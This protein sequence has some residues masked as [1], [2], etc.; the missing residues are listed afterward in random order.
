MRGRPVRLASLTVAL[1][2]LLAASAAGQTTAFSGTYASERWDWWGTRSC[3]NTAPF[4]G[5]EPAT[6][7][8][9]P[10][11]VYLPGTSE[12][13]DGPVGMRFV[14]AMAARGFVAASVR[15]EDWQFYAEGLEG[16]AACI[17]GAGAGGAVTQLCARP[18]ADCSRGIVV[19]GFSQGAVIS[20]RARNHDARVRAAYLLGFN[21]ERTSPWE[22]TARWRMAVTA[23]AGTR[24]LPD[25]RIRIV[26][27]ADDAPVAQRDELNAQTG[28]S[29]AT[30]AARCLARNGAG[31]YVVQHGQVADGWAD[32]CYFQGG[33]TC[34]RTPAFD[35]TWATSAGAPWA[36]APG[37]AWLAS[38]AR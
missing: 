16:N 33:G 36:L 8:G 15:Y 38:F 32:H 26:D 1:T 7:A 5:R 21:E 3:G 11:F 12:P 13:H 18:R 31:W 37:L 30:T 17:Y 9:H 4:A 24:A 25:T 10:V 14:A 23:P 34:P 19:A 6:G 20:A 27:G 35:P 2:V 28:R 22:G 29:C